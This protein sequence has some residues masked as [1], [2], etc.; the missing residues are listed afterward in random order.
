MSPM[1]KASQDVLA[2]LGR[3]EGQSGLEEFALR[4]ARGREEGNA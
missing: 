3:R 2:E 1:N 4:K